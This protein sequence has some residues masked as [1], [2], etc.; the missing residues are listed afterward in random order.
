M[1]ERIILLKQEAYV[2]KIPP[3]Q[4]PADESTGWMAKGW[5]L[6]K[7]ETV[8]L[9]LVSKGTNCTLKLG[10]KYVVNI[11]TFPGPMVQTVVDSSRYFV[12]NPTDGPHLGLGFA[13]RSDSFDF[14]MALNEHF[15]AL[16]VD[17]EIAKE[18]EEPRERLDLALKE[19]QTI[20]VNI[21]IPRKSNRERSRSPATN[22]KGVLPPPSAAAI[23]AG[24]LP[25]SSATSNPFAAPAA[26]K[27][28]APPT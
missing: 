11:D 16:R 15:K 21:N 28:N 6:N 25:P 18:E 26:P 1:I 23:A 20:K 12:I 22:T 4:V 2:Y 13:D 10:E 3:A 19:G 7:P 27:L 24:I 9:K 8:K 14:N 17:A 5:D